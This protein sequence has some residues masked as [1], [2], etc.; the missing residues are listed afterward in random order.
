MRVTRVTRDRFRLLGL[1][2]VMVGIRVG[3]RVRIRI[4]IRAKARDRLRMV[5]TEC[6]EG[7]VV[8]SGVERED[9]AETTEPKRQK[10][11][12]VT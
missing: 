2:L 3:I 12:R 11:D 7:W 1:V 10:Q 8:L 5:Q 9:R 4:R 6:E